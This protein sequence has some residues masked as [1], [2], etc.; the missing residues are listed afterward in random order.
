MCCGCNTIYHWKT[1]IMICSFVVD[2]NFDLKISNSK[3]PITSS[4]KDHICK[5]KA[6]FSEDSSI[7]SKTSCFEFSHSLRSMPSIVLLNLSALLLL[8][9]GYGIFHYLSMRHRRFWTRNLTSPAWLWCIL[10]ANLNLRR[11]HWTADELDKRVPILGS[12][13]KRP[14]YIPILPRFS[15]DVR[16]QLKVIQKVVDESIW[17]SLALSRFFCFKRAHLT[18]IRLNACACAQ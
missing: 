12:Y 2:S 14:G 8:Q 18:H 11:K 17:F 4:I 13:P 15:P 6:F 5:A 10:S 3:C 1:T 16:N 7:L 9:R